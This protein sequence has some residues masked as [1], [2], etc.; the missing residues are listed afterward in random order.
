MYMV[1]QLCRVPRRAAAALDIAAAARDLP[2]PS[3]AGRER[4]GAPRNLMQT[5]AGKCGWQRS[6]RDADAANR[7]E[8]SGVVRNLEGRNEL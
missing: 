4:G 6:A 2:M 1:G 3:P 7:K 5:W 8:W